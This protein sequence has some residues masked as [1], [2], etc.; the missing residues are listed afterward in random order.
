MF[1]IFSDLSQLASSLPA[2]ALWPSLGVLALLAVPL[3]LRNV[4]IKQIRNA[5]RKL[6]TAEG[7]ER[8]RWAERAL[9]LAGSTP[10]LLSTVVR[11]SIKRSQLSLRD[12]GLKRLKATGKLT[13]DVREFEL[14]FARE[15]PQPFAHP[16][17]AI[18][19]VE[20][21][22][23]D[24]LPGKAAERLQAARRQFPTD[25][26]LLELEQRLAQ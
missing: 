15:E 12:E 11:E 10:F 20:R 19:V 7:D 9:E 4:R 21:L 6:V 3:W 17:E 14:A 16:L 26:S 8:Q 2:W 23:E 1:R 18:A 22:V 25:R 5:V 13:E 24:E